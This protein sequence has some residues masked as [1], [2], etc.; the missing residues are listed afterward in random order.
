MFGKHECYFFPVW[1][2]RNVRENVETNWK[3]ELKPSHL[4]TNDS[5]PDFAVTN[6]ARKVCSFGRSKITVHLFSSFFKSLPQMDGTFFYDGFLD[7]KKMLGFGMKTLYIYI[8][9]ES[10]LTKN[11]TNYR[12]FTSSILLFLGG[13]G[14][15]LHHL[16]P[17]RF[18]LSFRFRFRCSCRSFGFA[19]CKA[20]QSRQG[21]SRRS[22]GRRNRRPWHSARIQQCIHTR[23]RGFHSNG[24]WALHTHLFPIGILATDC[25]PKPIGGRVLRTILVGYSFVFAQDRVYLCP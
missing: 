13:L 1:A 25:T 10:F 18:S 17:I 9:H 24:T 14:L 21:H 11:N 2:A 23:S 15:L 8:G 16:F 3:T 12:P 5:I 19:G 20:N 4:S 6:W 7:S 22:S